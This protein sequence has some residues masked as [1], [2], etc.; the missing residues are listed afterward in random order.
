M[1]VFLFK[2]EEEAEQFVTLG[3]PVFGKDL[4]GREV[5]DRGMTTKAANPLKHPTLKEWY[6]IFDE[7][8]T[9]REGQIIDIDFDKIFPKQ[10]F[11]IL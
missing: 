5:L 3:Y 10:D 9:E 1:K 4:G 8:F 7:S 2:S 11:P 6:V